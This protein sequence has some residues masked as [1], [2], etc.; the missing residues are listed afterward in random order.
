M[1]SNTTTTTDIRSIVSRLDKRCRHI[2]SQAADLAYRNQHAVLDIEHVMAS[3]CDAEDDPLLKDAVAAGF[4][5]AAARARLK[6]LLLTFRS[7]GGLPPALSDRLVGAL[8]D[9][10]FRV[11]LEPGS[12]AVSIEAFLRVVLSASRE[13]SNLLIDA[14]ELV[15]LVSVLQ[16]GTTPPA[17]RDAAQQDATV[18]STLLKY[19]VDLTARAKAGDIDPILGRDAEISQVVEIL[20][21]RRQ[22]NPILTGEAG[23]GK[24]AIVEGLAQRIAAGLVPQALKNVR[25][26]SLDMGLLRAGSA[27]RGEIELRI[28]AIIAEIAT[29]EQPVILFIDEAHTLVAGAA[30]HGEQSDIAN[31]IKPELA[32]GTLRTIAATTWAEY[33]RYFEKDAALSRR[34][35][36]VRVA[37]PSAAVTEDILHGL[38]PVLQKHHGVYVMQSAVEAAV[39]LSSRYIQDRQLPDKAISVLDTACARAVAALTGPVNEEVGLRQRA[40]LLAARLIALQRERAWTGLGDNV[41]AAVQLDLNAIHANLGKASTFN[42]ACAAT[43][44]PADCPPGG[45]LPSEQSLPPVRVGS[46]DVA[47]VIADW[48]GVPSQKMLLDQFTLA[49][50]LEEALAQRVVGQRAAIHIICDRVRAYSAKLEDPSRPIG[51]FMLTGP[52]GVGKTE[53]AHAL[54]EAFFGQAGITVVNMSEYQEAHTVSKLKGAPAGYVGYGQGGVLTEA[55]RRQPYGLL[56]LDEVEKAHPDVLDL[57]LQ[58]F[59]KGFMEDSEGIVI[60]FKNTLVLMT[61]N[62]GSELLESYG[63]SGDHGVND[64]AALGPLLQKQLLQYFK[65]AFLG[66]TQVVPYFTLAE[67]E[68]RCIVTLKIRALSQ[69]FEDSYREVLEFDP[70]VIDLVVAHCASRTIGARWI[71]QYIS[72]NILSRLSSYVLGC[73]SQGDPVLAVRVVTCNDGSMF[74]EPLGAAV[75]VDASE[76]SQ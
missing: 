52:S 66:R 3:F 46:E 28:K 23:V 19:T 7:E 8:R 50:R 11:S 76:A 17:A 61:S 63:H 72:E 38:L 20:L 44:A 16:V 58:V 10:W 70:K 53:T 54:A 41:I 74:V 51:V 5:V 69:R 2:V 68:L 71:D 43:S 33:K 75:S 30:G 36:T 18:Y 67:S 62:A 40:E 26:C 45:G 73:L 60:D 32:R 55:I 64:L 27:M 13:F 31:L 22:N 9:A 56:L 24:T 6:G 49:E 57:F 21:R 29:A 39:R 47:S 1:N 14:P 37:E 34:F 65:P 59:D 15:K 48:T 4:Q 12:H 42:G 25:I 35:Q